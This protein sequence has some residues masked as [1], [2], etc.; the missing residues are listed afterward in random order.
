MSKILVVD[1]YPITRKL[2]SYQLRNYG[3]ET[4]LAANGRE[5]LRC[6]SE[7]AVDLAILDIAMPEMDGI[8][9]LIRLRADERYM[10][11]PGIMLTASG[12]D[13]DRMIAETE[14]ISGFLTK[15]DCSIELNEAV[16]RCLQ[17]Q[18]QI[19]EDHPERK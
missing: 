13:N 8:S 19:A 18:P 10:S 5:A 6:L 12:Q 4:I 3:H 17:T 14:G 7:G 11:L 2:L 15:P 1:D 16:T 9:L